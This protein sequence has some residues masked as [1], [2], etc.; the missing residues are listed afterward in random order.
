M[1]LKKDFETI[2]VDPGLTK[3]KC[4]EL[5]F[6]FDSHVDRKIENP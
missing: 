4:I 3:C 2:K 5:S 6:T 1:F